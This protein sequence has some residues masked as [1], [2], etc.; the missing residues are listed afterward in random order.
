ALSGGHEIAIESDRWFIEAI[1]A[2]VRGKMRA[3]QGIDLA[4]GA[5]AAQWDRRKPKWLRRRT[6]RE[7]IERSLRAEAKRVGV[8]VSHEEF[9]AFCNKIAVLLELVYS[10]QV[11]LD[12]IAF[13]AS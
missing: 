2:V 8:D 6:F 9:G 7:R 12:A 4:T 11:P 10:G 13:E 5:V 1:H 3:E